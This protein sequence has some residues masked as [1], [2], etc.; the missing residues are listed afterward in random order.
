MIGFDNRQ[1]IYMGNIAVNVAALRTYIVSLPKGIL[2]IIL[3]YL[4]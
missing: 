2:V 1:F 3:I 4:N